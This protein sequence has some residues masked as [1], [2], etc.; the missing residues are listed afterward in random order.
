MKSQKGQV[1]L[2][3][4]GK[5]LLLFKGLMN[6]VSEKKKAE[7]ATED[8]AQSGKDPLGMRNCLTR[9]RTTADS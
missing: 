8:Q 7:W 3:Q 1:K 4:V 6:R 9:E 5:N 2:F